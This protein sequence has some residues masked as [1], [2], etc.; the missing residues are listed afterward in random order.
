MSLKRFLR[1]KLKN[2]F[3]K[4]FWNKNLKPISSRVVKK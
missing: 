4:S 3:V 2:I 1:N